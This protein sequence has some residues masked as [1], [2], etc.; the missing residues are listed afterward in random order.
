MKVDEL[1]KAR[2]GIRL[3]VGCGANKQGPDWVGMDIQSL[4]GVDIVH[5]WNVHPW[6]LP[7][8]C[9][10]VAMCSHVLEHVPPVVLDNGKTRL[11]FIEFMNDLWRV[12]KPDAELAI[13]MPHGSSQGYLQDPTHCNS[14]NETTWAYFDP[15][16]PNTAGL[17]YKFYRPK[18]W[19]IKFLTWAPN[20]NMEVVLV[21][22]REDPSYNA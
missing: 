1:I 19:R 5:D 6:P 22:R 12:L 17:L 14:C 16:E 2:S 21:K 9:V 7:D 11:L 10:L 4:P 13:A 8:E 3:D 20:G 18:P 15:L